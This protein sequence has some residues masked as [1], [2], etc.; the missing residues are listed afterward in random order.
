M[1]Q[2]MQRLLAL[3][4]LEL[5]VTP[6]SSQ[7]EET[8]LQL[9]AQIP[10]PILDHFDRLIAR[11][12]KGVATVRGM[13]CGECHLVISI[14]TLHQLE[15]QS[16]ICLCGNCGRYLYLPPAVPAAQADA[17][18]PAT[19]AVRRPRRKAAPAAAGAA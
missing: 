3:Q 7:E 12:K 14:G 19:T 10:K 5:N 16:D 6:R 13:S 2:L 1:K 15:H 8:V 11:G 9:R 18:K 17:P 4:T